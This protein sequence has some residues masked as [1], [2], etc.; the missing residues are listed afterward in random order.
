M[1]TGT[2]ADN[3]PAAVAGQVAA[4]ELAEPAAVLAV[5]VAESPHPAAAV[6]SVVA[7]AA[8]NFLHYS[9]FLTR[10]RYV[11]ATIYILRVI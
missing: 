4:V 1:D 8:D 9:S 7:V 3:K 2:A 5:V 11:Q 6:D 10:G